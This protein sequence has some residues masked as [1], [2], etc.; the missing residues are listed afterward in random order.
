MW[1][2]GVIVIESEGRSWFIEVDLS[3]ARSAV[4]RRGVV[5]K[6]GDRTGPRRGGRRGVPHRDTVFDPRDPTDSTTVPDKNRRNDTARLSQPPLTI[7]FTFV[8]RFACASRPD[9]G[10]LPLSGAHG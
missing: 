6:I 5:V 4:D 1:T 8:P 2:R 3:V 9:G 7:T 10:R